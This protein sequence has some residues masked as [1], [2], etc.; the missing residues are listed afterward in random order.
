VRIVFSTEKFANNLYRDV[1]WEKKVCKEE[2][3]PKKPFQWAF[4]EKQ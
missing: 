2:N 1:K 4:Y 3:V